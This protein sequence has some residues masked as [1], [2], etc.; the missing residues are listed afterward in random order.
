MTSK[1]GEKRK[2]PSGE[3]DRVQPSSSTSGT[4]SAFTTLMNRPPPPPP[5]EKKPKYS[6]FAGRDG[7]GEY[8]VKPESFPPTVVI[9]HNSACVFIKDLFPK[10]SIHALLLPRDPQKCLVNPFDAFED[11]VFLEEMKKQAETLK[12]LVAK[13]LKRRY[14]KFSEKDKKFSEYEQREAMGELVESEVR[15]QGRDW[16]SEVKVG[17]HAGPSMNHLHVHVISRDNYS[18]CLKK[19]LHY[20]SFNTNFFVNIEELPLSKSERNYRQSSDTRKSQLSQD[21][22]CWRCGMN[23]KRSFVRLKEHLAIEFEAWKKE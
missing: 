7:L 14:G 19:A 3:V 17:F 8:L 11:E 15:P 23:F 22:E 18:S 13:D 12:K 6:G 20:N 2:K 5:P 21:F 10:A 4:K 16:E 1:P 9:A